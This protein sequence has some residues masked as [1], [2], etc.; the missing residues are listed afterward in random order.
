MTYLCRSRNPKL[1][2]FLQNLLWD[3]IYASELPYGIRLRLGFYLKLYSWLASFPSLSFFIHP[4]SP[5]SVYL[6]N[7]LHLNPCLR[8]CI[9]GDC[10]K[11]TPSLII[12][13]SC[14]TPKQDKSGPLGS[15]LLFQAYLLLLSLAYSM[16]CSELAAICSCCCTFSYVL[17]IAPIHSSFNI[18]LKYYQWWRALTNSFFLPTLGSFSLL[19]LKI[20]T[21][22]SIAL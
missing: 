6:I 1:C 14:Q 7:H 12:A 2:V 10:P 8:V 15:W 22:S 20:V 13:M 4:V 5:G 3:L 11:I 9:C 19:L 18:H 21:V 16:V 17:L